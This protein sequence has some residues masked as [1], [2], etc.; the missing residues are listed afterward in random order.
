MT[1]EKS[2]LTGGKPN[3]KLLPSSPQKARCS[4]IMSWTQETKTEV[5]SH[6][7]SS[8]GPIPWSRLT[9]TLPVETSWATS[10][11]PPS[12]LLPQNTSSRSSSSLTIQFYW[13]VWQ[14]AVRP[15]WP[16][17]SWDPSLRNSPKTTTINW[18]TSRIILTPRIF[19]FNWSSFWKRLPVSSMDH[20]E[21]RNSSTLSMTLTCHNLIRMTHK[22]PSLCWDNM[23]TTSIG[24]MSVSLHSRIS[25]TL[26]PWL[27]SIPVQV[28]SLSTP[29]TWDI[30]GLY[31]SHS[32][33][34][35]HCP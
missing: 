31:P 13:S 24:M 21:S 4:T 22:A 17:V 1:T 5:W 25:S 18:S 2:F 27:P 6:A 7:S 3:G 20:Q 14:V 19:K 29:D 34:T 8:N 11:S 28:H 33:I 15:N 32:P 10:Q 23:L 35:S 12:K 26:K 30:S 9:S 16:R